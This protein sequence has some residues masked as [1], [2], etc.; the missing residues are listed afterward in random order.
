MI[1]LA[2]HHAGSVG[3]PVID[4]EHLLFSL[5]REEKDHFKLFFPLADSK[6]TVWKE[7]EKHLTAGNAFGFMGRIL[8]MEELPP[9]RT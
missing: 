6:D 7:L 9:F 8:P 1:F 5:V 2:K 3:S 4:A